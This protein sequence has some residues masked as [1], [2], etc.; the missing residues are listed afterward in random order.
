MRMQGV[1][2]TELLQEMA[3]A[4]EEME[5]EG[6][7]EKESTD[8]Q[9]SFWKQYAVCLNDEVETFNPLI[10]R[11]EELEFQRELCKDHADSMPQ[12]EK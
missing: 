7:E 10:G 2:M 3:M 8:S 6:S 9:E 4:N 11:E 12:G 1:E 5:F